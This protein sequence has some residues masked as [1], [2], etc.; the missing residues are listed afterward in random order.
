[1]TFL[2][3]ETV[4]LT[5]TQVT[6]LTQTSHSGL[7]VQTVDLLGYNKQRHLTSIK[8][9]LLSIFVLFFFEIVQ[10][11]AETNRYYHQY[12]DTLDEGQFPLPDMTV[13]NMCLFL[14]IIVQM[15]HGQ[16]GMLKDYWSTLGQYLMA[17]YRNTVKRD[18][19][20]HILRF[21]HFS[22]NKNER[23]KTHENYN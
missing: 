15:G 6:L 14:A 17:L 8:T 20:C 18:R 12:L 22:D 16:R 11:L 13:Q 21:L 5:V 7:T 1:M 23:D 2:L 10:L 19:F 9:L 4:A 3:R